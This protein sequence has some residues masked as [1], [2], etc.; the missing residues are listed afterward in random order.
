MYL[1]PSLSSHKLCND[2]VQVPQRQYSIADL[3]LN[4]IEPSL[5]LSPVDSTLGQVQRNLQIAAVAG[6][7]VIWQTVHPSQ[8][9]VISAFLALTFFSGVDLVRYSVPLSPSLFE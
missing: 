2:I 4:D 1:T 8:F 9:Q 5:F 7:I 6:A 3:R